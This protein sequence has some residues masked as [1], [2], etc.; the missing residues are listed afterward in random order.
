MFINVFPTARRRVSTIVSVT[1][2][3]RSVFAWHVH[4]YGDSEQ[5]KKYRRLISNFVFENY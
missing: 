4:E 2:T 1:Y 5:I 3:V